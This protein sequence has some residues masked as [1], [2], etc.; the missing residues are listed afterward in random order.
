MKERA[1]VDP[2]KKVE[3]DMQENRGATEELL[4]MS[5]RKDHGKREENDPA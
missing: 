1:I 5:G 4:R 2:K 3:L